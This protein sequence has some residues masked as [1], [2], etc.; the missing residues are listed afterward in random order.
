MNLG[1]GNAVV[2]AEL[3]VADMAQGIPLAA[4]LK[5]EAVHVVIAI[6]VP[7][8]GIVDATGPEPTGLMADVKYVVADR[9]SPRQLRVELLEWQ[10]ERNHCSPTDKLCRPESSL[11]VEEIESSQLIIVTPEPPRR[12]R[13]CTTLDRK[14]AIRGQ[15][16]DVAH[17]D[18][19]P[20]T[21]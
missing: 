12:A 8:A 17:V 18:L 3:A 1:V 4:G 20:Q 15:V 16:V 19:L 5:P 11:V 9:R 13:G 10:V 6:E 7:R 14:V 21:H 2:V